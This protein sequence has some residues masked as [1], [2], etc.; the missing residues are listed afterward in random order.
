MAE[1]DRI[2]THQEDR[3]R[4]I[5]TLDGE[6]AGFATYVEHGDVRNFDHTVVDP[7]FRGQ[8]L[9]SPLIRAALDDTRE[10]GMSVVPSCSAVEHFIN[11]NEEYKD[12]LPK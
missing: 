4:F 6:E 12:L 2:V 3:A 9:S 10:R 5:I 8:G 7:K 1:Q 11:K